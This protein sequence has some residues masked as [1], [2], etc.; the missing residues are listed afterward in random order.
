M[1]G[2]GEFFIRAAVAP[3]FLVDGTARNV[4]VRSGRARAGSCRKLG[5]QEVSFGG[6]E[7][8][9]RA[10]FNT[11]GM[12]RGYIWEDGKFVSEIYNEVGRAYSL[13]TPQS[14]RTLLPSML[15]AISVSSLPS[16]SSAHPRYAGYDDCLSRKESP[17]SELIVINDG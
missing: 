17:G 7:W 9:C 8:K 5:G 15:P 14:K 2:D 10:A 13:R 16:M 4:T 3:R 1:H 12:Y 11:S 6:Q